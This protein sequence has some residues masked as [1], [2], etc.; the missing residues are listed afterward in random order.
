MS[1]AA[2]QQANKQ[3]AQHSTGPRTEEGK[4]RTSQNALKHGLYATDPLIRGEDPDDFYA[5]GAELE[6]QLR[7]ANAV[8]EDLVE[9]IIDITWRLKRCV[10]IE[11]AVI[12][13]LYDTVAAQPQN[14]DKDPDELLGKAL[15]H[16][17]ALSRHSRR[18]TRLA[19]RYHAAMKELRELRKQ[20]APK[21]LFQRPRCRA[22]AQTTGRIDSRHRFRPRHQRRHRNDGTDPIRRN[23]I[24][25]NSPDQPAG[26]RTRPNRPRPQRP[27][28]DPA[29]NPRR[30][31][32]SG[33]RQVIE[34]PSP[35]HEPP[36]PKTPYTPP[37]PKAPT[38]PGTQVTGPPAEPS[39]LASRPAA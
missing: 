28:S 32:Q 31:R 18:E 6:Y 36:H 17:D 13:E 24:R 15:T 12:N 26:P 25:I 39:I 3:N 27:A 38:E 20:R 8:E 19:R 10:R 29:G 1:T 16:N 22:A 33:G 23:S 21:R 7:P 2:Q 30:N 14:H 11:S 37:A 35:H 4:Q 5:H 34:T 9:Q